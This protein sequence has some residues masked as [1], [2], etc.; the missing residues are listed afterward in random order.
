MFCSIRW[1]IRIPNPAVSGN[2]SPEFAIR[3]GSKAPAPKDWSD[4]DLWALRAILMRYS[5][6]EGEDEGGEGANG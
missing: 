6:P 1:E 5:G 3:F 4:E 2:P